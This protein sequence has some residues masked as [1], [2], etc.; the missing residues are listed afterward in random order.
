MNPM[1]GRTAPTSCDGASILP[2][3]CATVTLVDADVNARSGDGA[4]DLFDVSERWIRV[5]D[6]VAAA[7][8]FTAAARRL[9]L[10]QPAVS[11]TIA[12]LE[13]VL[14][15]ALFDR[16]PSGAHLTAAGIELRD[17]V[18]PALAALDAGV[19]AVRRTARGAGVVALSVSTSFATWWLLPRLT[20]F[21]RRHPDVDLRCIT[22]DTDAGVG[23]DDAD[24]W[25]PLGPDPWPGLARHELTGE[26]IVA[27]AAPSLADRL[28]ARDD[29]AALRDADLIHLEE[30]YRPRFDWTLWFRHHGLAPP[31]L[32][33]ARSN[34]YAVV[35]QAALDGQGVALGWE[36]LVA[37]LIDGGRLVVVG[38]APIC[39]RRPFVVLHRRGPVS[40]ATTA[41]RDWLLAQTTSGRAAP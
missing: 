26:R 3:P 34:D 9:H 4:I 29:P 18:R 1:V 31:P 32:H 5:F 24:L 38:G 37:P 28:S 19:R 27:V 36:H 25:L 33:G 16:T 41:L 14:G 8:S 11:H 39:T 23:V 35:V 15:T 13:R 2:M 22:N 20:D 7:G 12:Q 21:K 40:S 10:G 30:R 6:V 17:H